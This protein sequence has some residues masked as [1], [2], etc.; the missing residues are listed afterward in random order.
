MNQLISPP[1]YSF[2]NH[3]HEVPSEVGEWELFM[4]DLLDRI[5][6]EDDLSKKMQLMEYSGFVF[7]ILKKLDYAEH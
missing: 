2:D 7:R 1:E 3:L 6:F 4:N 5:K